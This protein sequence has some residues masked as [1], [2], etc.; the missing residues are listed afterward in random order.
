MEIQPRDSALSLGGYVGVQPSSFN[1]TL[2]GVFDRSLRD[3][4]GAGAF[5]QYRTFGV[6]ADYADGNSEDGFRKAGSLTAVQDLGGA[7]ALYGRY[8][9][10]GEVAENDDFTQNS[11]FRQ[12][13]AVA[14]LGITM[15][16]KK[17]L[18]IDLPNRDI[19]VTLQGSLRDSES[20]SSFLT[21]KEVGAVFMISYQV[22]FG[23]KALSR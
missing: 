17:V 13:L 10:L 12:D 6:F 15:N 7:W 22:T 1:E 2:G 18:G 20:D 5:L 16:A 8:Y 4:L 21:D 14:A 3:T 11:G 23:G 9:F 19:F